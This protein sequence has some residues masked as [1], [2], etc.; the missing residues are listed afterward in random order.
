MQ[1]NDEK[2]AGFTE[3][4]AWIEIANNYQ[5]I[6]AQ[7]QLTDEKSI[8]SFYKKCSPHHMNTSCK[9]FS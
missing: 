6:N 5:S 2:N 9:H 1:W 7:S 4:K 3:G 8:Y